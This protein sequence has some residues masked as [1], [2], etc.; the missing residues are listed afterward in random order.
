M[1]SYPSTSYP[2]LLSHSDPN[3]RSQ[4]LNEIASL[5]PTT[6]A[7]ALRLAKPSLLTALTPLLA[8]TN[9]EAPLVLQILHSLLQVADE[10]AS[11]LTNT[12][13]AVSARIF[14]HDVFE[15]A[16]MLGKVRYAHL[17]DGGT[18]LWLYK[19]LLRTR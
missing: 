4:T 1:T 17:I 10:T 15:A 13:N 3:V 5:F 7:T 9:P 12:E 16:V 2:S 19:F 11:K 6:T 14:T 18:R 8:P